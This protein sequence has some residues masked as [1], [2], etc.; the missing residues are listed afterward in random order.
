MEQKLNQKLKLGF[1]GGVGSVTGANFLLENS[2]TKILVD[3]GLIQGYFKDTDPNYDKFQYEPKE[4]DYLIITHA[5]A[6]HIGRIGKLVKDG[7]KG[8][9]FSTPATKDLATLMIEDAL[10][11]MH[12]RKDDKGT[13]MMYEEKDFSDALSRWFTVDY[14][15]KETL[16]GFDILFRDAGHILGSAFVEVVDVDSKKKIV[17][18]GDLGN[19][20]T[21]LL[22]NTEVLKDA[23]YLVIESVYGDRNH[24]ERD[25]RKNKLQEVIRKV[26]S[27]G[28]TLIIPVF[29]LE[30]TQVL[31]KELNDLIE[32]KKVQSVPVFF[33]SPLGIRLTE[34][35]GN[36][37]HLFNEE[38]QKEIKAGDDIFDF[39]KLKMTLRRQDSDGIMKTN[40]AKIII[41]SS[42]MSEGGRV[43]A[44]EKRYLS[45]PKNAILFIGYQ[46]AGSL[47]RRIQEGM[48]NVTIEGT[49]IRVRADVLT[50][51]GYSSH[52]DSNGLLDFVEGSQETLKKVFVV[53]GE[54]KSSLYLTQKIRE[55]L[56]V[57]A[58]VPEL[59][60]VIELG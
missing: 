57:D 41:A 39:P 35:Y 18:S 2:H 53:M 4:I 23:D 8:K 7:F 17:F 19:S 14:H 37:T 38:V 5:H 25:Q 16:G 46:V 32:D 27:R 47:G 28:G 43:T 49:D 31:L 10:N 15:Q 12:K 33:D 40:G 59:G 44:H 22:R 30:K 11:L 29:S 6:D 51:S 45:D 56:S 9:I 1:Y 36:Y 54:V 42:G 24:E 60:D 34:V 26:V 21:P 13:Q 52:K 20:P 50:V 55:F 58:E 48:K 3:C